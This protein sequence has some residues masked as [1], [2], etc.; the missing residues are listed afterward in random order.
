MCSKF[1]GA[2]LLLNEIDILKQNIS[3]AIFYMCSRNQ[4]NRR[5]RSQQPHL[6]KREI[7]GP[8]S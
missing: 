5:H 1:L 6:R 3:G 7:A 8:T 4:R 2:V